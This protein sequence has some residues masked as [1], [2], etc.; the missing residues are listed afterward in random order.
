MT[1]T[2]YGIILGD[3]IGGNGVTVLYAYGKS[4]QKGHQTRQEFINYLWEQQQYFRGVVDKTLTGQMKTEGPIVE[5]SQVGRQQFQSLCNILNEGD[6]KQDP[7]LI[8]RF[9]QTF[10]GIRGQEYQRPEWIDKLLSE[11]TP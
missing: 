3:Q 8:E 6:W 4:F 7:L 10:H 11:P 1:S 2:T 5:D 9:L